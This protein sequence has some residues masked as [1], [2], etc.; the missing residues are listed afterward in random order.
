MH[1][2]WSDA[3]DLL[4]G[5]VVGALVRFLVDAWTDRYEAREATARSTAKI[6]FHSRNKKERKALA[7]FILAIILVLPC[8]FQSIQS[9]PPILRH[10]QR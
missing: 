6:N 3:L 2:I 8:F 4:T 7:L 5:G 1:K 10:G 9:L